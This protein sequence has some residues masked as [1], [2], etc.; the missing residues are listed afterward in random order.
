MY[1]RILI[2]VLIGLLGGCDDPT[3]SLCPVDTECP[4]PYRVRDPEGAC[5]WACASGTIPSAETGEC[6]CTEGKQN[7]GYEDG[8]GRRMC[9]VQS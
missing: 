4:W 2:A 7:V 9:G 5:V 3:E 6:E 8:Y 1:T